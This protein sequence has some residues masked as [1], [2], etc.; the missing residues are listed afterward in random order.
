MLAN[1]NILYVFVSLFFL[2]CVIPDSQAFSQKRRSKSSSRSYSSK[3]RKKSSKPRKSTKSY[4]KKS[5]YST[6]SKS[7]VGGGCAATTA[8]GTA[9]K[10]SPSAGSSYCWQ[11]ARMYGSETASNEPSSK[12]ASSVKQY[13]GGCAATT[14]KGTACKRSP[15]GDSKYCWQHATMYDEDQD[16]KDDDDDGDEDTIEE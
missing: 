7:S 4:A 14:L 3:P 5:S 2:A 9:C 13:S 1:R 11:H 15:S 8:K 16:K 12:T 6:K 10:R